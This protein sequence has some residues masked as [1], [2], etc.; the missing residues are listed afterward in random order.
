MNESLLRNC[1]ACGNEIS[2]HSP[3]C[4]NCG[5]PQ[6]AP[7]MIWLLVSFLL[8]TMASYLA[9]TL[10][11]ICHVHELQQ[12]GSS[13]ARPAAPTACPVLHA[14]RSPTSTGRAIRPRRRAALTESKHCSCS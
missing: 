4:R 1:K 8:L 2:R 10:H 11:G 5:H 9:F 13:R 6:G 12:P 14:T 3:S 7:L